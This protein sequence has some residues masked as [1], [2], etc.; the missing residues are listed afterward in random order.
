M[1][2]Q[3]VGD[4]E[5]WWIRANQGHSL[6]VPELALKS[7]SSIEDAPSMVIHGTDKRLWPSIQRDGLRT[8][9]RNHIHMASGMPGHGGVIS[10]M[11]SR[12]SLF[13]HLDILRLLQGVCLF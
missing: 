3:R 9:G 2:H 11:R 13:I 6:P 8:M 1:V 10:G 12:C 5:G 4:Q 7:I